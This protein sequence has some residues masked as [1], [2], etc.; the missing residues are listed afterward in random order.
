MPQ[1]PMA[2]QGRA[3][4]GHRA[5]VHATMPEGARSCSQ[6][7]AQ[8]LHASEAR[9]R[10]AHS[11][12][13]QAPSGACHQA[14]AAL[15][16]SRQGSSPA[17]GIQAGEARQ[18][19]QQHGRQRRPL[20]VRHRF[21]SAASQRQNFAETCPLGAGAA[22]GAAACQPLGHITLA[23]PPS[24]HLALICCLQAKVSAALPTHP[25]GSLYSTAFLEDTG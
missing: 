3:A 22:P 24:G 19:D 5:R 20:Q 14:P 18:E 8:V 15:H 1:K 13:R 2:C 23:I 12:V 25:Q 11:A 7:A 6:E 16:R 10:G 17:A 9:A 4:R 21:S